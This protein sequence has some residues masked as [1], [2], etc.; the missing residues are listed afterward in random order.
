MIEKLYDT[1]EIYRIFVPLPENPLKMLNSYII[2]TP[3]ESLMLDTGFNRP[4]CKEALMEGLKELDVD[5]KNTSIF[6]THLHSDHVGLVPSMLEEEPKRVY[7][8]AV[9][10]EYLNRDHTGYN[11]SSLEDRYVSEGFPEE[12][13]RALRTSNQARIFAPPKMFDVIKIYDGDIV[14]VG[15]YEFECIH[16]PGHTPGHICLYFK[17]EKILFSGDHVLFDIT[18]NNTA[19]PGIEDSLGDYLKSLDKIV[20]YD[21]KKT[22]PAHRGEFKTLYERVEEL[23]Q[24]HAERLALVIKIL[25]ELGEGTAWEVAARLKWSMRGKP[26]EEFPDNQKWFALGETLSHLDYLVL[27]N[28]VERTEAED[29]ILYRLIP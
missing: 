27:R 22:F 9:D 25:E 23:R 24:H 1:P 15:E 18:P 29:K 14:K 6:L 28:K 16:T 12:T 2:R 26:W 5:I 4:E 19:W 20:S 21:V 7:M 8:G 11:W 13:M 3:E 10:Y 17:E